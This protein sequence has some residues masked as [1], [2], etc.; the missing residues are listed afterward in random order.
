MA[1]IDTKK[2]RIN[3]DL[4]NIKL[5]KRSITNQRQRLAQQLARINRLIESHITGAASC[6]QC[7]SEIKPFNIS[8]TDLDVFKLIYSKTMSD[9]KDEDFMTAT[10]QPKNRSEIVAAMSKAMTDRDLLLEVVAN[11]PDQAAQ[12]LTILEGKIKG[13]KAA[14]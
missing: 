5:T 8:K 10:D 7:N 1:R 14:V 6:E 13:I 12:C 3:K 4:S 9:I 11:H 2:V